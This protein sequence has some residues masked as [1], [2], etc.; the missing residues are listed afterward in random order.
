MVLITKSDNA[1][2]ICINYRKPN[3]IHLSDNYPIPRISDAL[4]KIRQ[5]QYLGL[6]DFLVPKSYYRIRL[7]KTPKKNQHLRH[8]MVYMSL[9]NPVWNEDITSNL[10][11]VLNWYSNAIAYFDDIIIFSDTLSK[12]LDHIRTVLDKI[13]HAGLSVRSTKCKLGQSEIMCL[14]RIIGSGKT[15]PDL[16]KITAR[17]EFPLQLTKK[18]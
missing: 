12:H 6:F 8:H 2:K 16:K 11:R 3:D 17:K 18:D 5:P 9:K 13:K 14:G 10:D 15:W 4:E 7:S 1:I